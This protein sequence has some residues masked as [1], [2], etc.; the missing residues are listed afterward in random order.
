MGVEDRAS[1]PFARREEREPWELEVDGGERVR[2]K[3][4]EDGDP[5]VVYAGPEPPDSEAR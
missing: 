4:G 3:R 2:Y 5:V 1:S